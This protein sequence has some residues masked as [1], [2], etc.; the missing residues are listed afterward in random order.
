M[1]FDLLATRGSAWA[2]R[3]AINVA[4]AIRMARDLGPGHTI[5]TDPLRLRHPL[6]VEALQP[7]VPAREGPA[8]AGLARARGATS[9]MPA[10]AERR[11]P[12][13]GRLV[14]AALLLLVAAGG[15]A[16]AQ[17]AAEVDAERAK[18][19]DAV[20]DRAPRRWSTT[21]T[22]RPRSSRRCASG[23]SPSA[24]RRSRP[25]RSG[26][27]PVDELNK[28]LQALG[29]PPAE[30]A[31]EAPEIATLRRDLQRADRRGAGAGADGAGGLP[32]HRRADRR[33]RP[34]RSAPASRPS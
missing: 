29:P 17:T 32:A 2:P 10:R 21:P 19:W 26:Q 7:G 8:G 1:V 33:D 23:S 16:L 24:A 25:S 18:R 9:P 15:G 13:G 27:P 22:P 14:A 20:G 6:P 11:S 4:G 28:R 3:P 31:E 30:G 12:A 34:R 5:V